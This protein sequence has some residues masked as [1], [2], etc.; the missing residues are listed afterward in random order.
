MN[1]GICVVANQGCK[2]PAGW[3]GYSGYATNTRPSVST[4]C[5]HCQEFVCQSC[6][7]KTGGVRICDLC[8]ED[9]DR[10]K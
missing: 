7:K 8:R 5:N 2:A 9:I 6:S 10:W 1:R 3:G 4:I